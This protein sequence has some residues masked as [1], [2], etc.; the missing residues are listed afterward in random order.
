MG[1]LQVYTGLKEY[2]W[3]SACNQPL[4]QVRNFGAFKRIFSFTGYTG[5]DII[6]FFEKLF[7]VKVK[8]V[9]SSIL[10][11]PVKNF[12]NFYFFDRRKGTFDFELP[13]KTQFLKYFKIIA[14]T[15][16][17][18]FYTEKRLIKFFLMK[19]ISDEIWRHLWFYDIIIE[20]DVI[21]RQISVL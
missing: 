3:F 16:L 19:P 20:Y 6:A 9:P 2:E 11:N 12:E 7:W 18:K 21:F 14:E 10:R 5:R 17:Q 13:L 8:S 15:S 4:L 1:F